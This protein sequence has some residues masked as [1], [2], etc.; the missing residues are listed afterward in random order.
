M[1]T[2]FLKPKELRQLKKMKV[3]LVCGMVGSGKTFIAKQVAKLLKAVYLSTDEVRWYEVVPYD[4][5]YDHDNLFKINRFDKKGFEKVYRTIWQRAKKYLSLDSKVVIDATFLN[6]RRKLWAT[7]LSRKVNGKLC[8]M[9]VKTNPEVI[10]KRLER[11]KKERVK[12]HLWE[13]G[14][15]GIKF[16]LNKIKNGEVKWPKP[17]DAPFYIEI[18]NDQSR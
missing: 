4:L 7:L 13:P 15:A 10:L 17:T 12:K 16:Y 3:V 6:R 9:H 18:N 14:L 1:L 5:G 11:R 2:K 8:L